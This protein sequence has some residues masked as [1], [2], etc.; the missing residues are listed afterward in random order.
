M[1][2]FCVCEQRRKEV[3]CIPAW[4]GIPRCSIV[5][6]DMGTLGSNPSYRDCL[7]NWRE[8]C[9]TEYLLTSDHIHSWIFWPT[10]SDCLSQ[11]VTSCYCWGLRHVLATSTVIKLER[12]ICRFIETHTQIFSLLT[13]K[14]PFLLLSFYHVAYDLH[15][16]WKSLSL[17]MLIMVLISLNKNAKITVGRMWS[18]HIFI[19]HNL[20]FMSW[21]ITFHYFCNQCVYIYQES[22]RRPSG[23]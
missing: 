20:M 11:A 16:I 12:P 22:N 23:L 10:K 3:S 13:Y 9:W 6:V 19:K 15:C 5:D 1:R 4:L 8:V 7:E 21:L 14:Y 2:W 17:S 18:Y